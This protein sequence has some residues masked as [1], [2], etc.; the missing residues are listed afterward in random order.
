MNYMSQHPLQLD[1]EC[2]LATKLSTFL[3]FLP[4][5][6]FHEERKVEFTVMCCFANYWPQYNINIQ[7][8]PDHIPRT[9]PNSVT[10]F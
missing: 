8:I 9:L 5:H 1:V 2:D 7:N 10:Y 6:H 3:P 4:G